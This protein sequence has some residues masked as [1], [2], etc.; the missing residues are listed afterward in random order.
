MA[1]GRYVL[2]ADVAIPAGVLSYAAAGPATASSGTTSATPD[3]RVP[4]SPPRR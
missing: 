3:G 4:R 2:T 1:L